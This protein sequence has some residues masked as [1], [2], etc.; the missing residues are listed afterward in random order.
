MPAHSLADKVRSK[1]L[2]GVLPREAPLKMSTGYPGGGRA[3]MAC[4]APIL[5]T[6]A[7]YELEM[8]DGV[9]LTMH[10]GCHGLWVAERVGSGNS[11]VAIPEILLGSDGA[12]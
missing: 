7:V 12:S 3:C 8:P 10:S 2:T 9:R 1:L 6:Q 11:A 4:E 5:S